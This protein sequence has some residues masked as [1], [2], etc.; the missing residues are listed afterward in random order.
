M[1]NIKDRVW[2]RA[3]YRVLGRVWN[4]VSDLVL[5][6]IWAALDDRKIS[7]AETI[8]SALSSKASLN[9]DY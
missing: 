9:T 1:K 8:S 4:G 2:G 5:N 7:L 3:R 6:E